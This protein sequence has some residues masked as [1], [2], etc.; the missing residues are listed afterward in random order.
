MQALDG[1]KML[2]FLLALALPFGF[3][4]ISGGNQPLTLLVRFLFLFSILVG[5]HLVLSHKK[6]SSPIF[7]SLTLLI[8]LVFLSLAICLGL[9]FFAWLFL[10]FY[11]IYLIICAES[12]MRSRIGLRLFGWLILF[13]SAGAVP[14]LINQINLR[15]S[16]EEFYTALMVVFLCIF[17]LVLWLSYH[18]FLS[19]HRKSEEATKT[20]L[21]SNAINTILNLLILIGILIFSII[22]YQKSFYPAQP[23][24]FFE[25]IGTD[26]PIL[27]EKISV[28]DPDQA[29]SVQAVQDKYAAA[30]ENKS[31]IKTLDLGFLAAYHQ[32]EPYFSQFKDS[33]LSDAASMRYTQPAGS[34]KWDQLLAAQTLYYYKT[35][36]EIKPNL[37]TQADT[38]EINA[39]IEAINKRAQT[40]ELVD[41]MYALAF[42]HKP[43]GAYLNQDIGAGLYALLNQLPLIDTSWQNENAEFLNEH[44][45]GWEQGF[46]VTDD[47]LTYQPVWITNSYFQALLANQTI[48][49]NT[50]RSFDWIL[51]QALPDAGLQTYNFP[52]QTTIAPISLF[53][54]IY[55]RDPNL[56][57]LANRSIET[58]GENY[59]YAV[60]V[61]SE[62]KIDEALTTE[63][64]QIGSCLLYGNSGLPEQTGPLAPDKVVLRNGWEK[65]D[66]YLML[67]L[68]FSGWHRYKASNAI[69]LIYAGAPLVEEQYT[70]EAI[71]WLPTGR[72]LVRDKRIQIEQLNTLLIKRGGLDAVLNT[73]NSWFGPYSQDPPYYA[74]V[75]AFSTSPELDYSKTSTKD[76]HGWDFTRELYLFQDGPA[77]IVDK[78]QHSENK[79]ANIRWHLSADFEEVGENRY[80]STRKNASLILLGQDA[81]Q[82]S[83]KP[84]DDLLVIEYQSPGSGQLEL[85]TIVLSG[86]LSKATFVSF[87]DNVLTLDLDGQLFEYELKP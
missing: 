33:L 66:L 46:R 3:L 14:G 84:S 12:L 13:V 30:I 7:A 49:D 73:L 55:L 37:F 31:N 2:R 50:I 42:S 29:V 52:S 77:I 64:P 68:R 56:L 18:F 85:V 4:L 20:P 58:I 21:R 40:D 81:G 79:S 57:W 10:A 75:E 23:Q 45:R 43:V 86:E 62:M 39:W 8:S 78:A 41:W 19:P 76:W 70:Q 27:C 17:W 48:N 25:G 11:Y 54:S 53:G 44:P 32:S 38:E 6:T 51:A 82:V 47:A 71:P 59:N 65:D 69:S 63:V 67:N 34:V 83:S 16:E 24:A 74:D 87:N 9:T 61:G 28:K 15:F 72:A 5:S 80:D 36:S 1:K 60:Q 26:N 35:V 22:R